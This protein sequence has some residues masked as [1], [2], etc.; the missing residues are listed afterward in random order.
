L[1]DVR[2][3][4]FVVSV[5]KS[6]LLLLSGLLPNLWLWIEKALV[7]LEFILLLFQIVDVLEALVVDSQIKGVSVLNYDQ[8]VVRHVERELERRT[9]HLRFEQHFPILKHLLFP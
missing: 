2:V 5:S 9:E 1:P 3:T 8:H 4:A 6:G 7:I